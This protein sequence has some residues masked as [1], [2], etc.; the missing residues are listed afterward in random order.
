MAGALYLHGLSPSNSL[1]R[2]W[3]L[4]RR[5]KRGQTPKCKMLFKPWPVSCFLRTHGLKPSH[6]AWAKIQ[7]VKSRFNLRPDGRAAFAMARFL[8]F[9][10]WPYKDFFSFFF[11]AMTC[12][13]WDRSSLT[14]DWTQATGSALSLPVSLCITG[15]RF[16]HLTRTD[17]N[18]FLFM[19]E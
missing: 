7:R 16:I 11:L 6:N 9:H 3:F 17:S 19:S 5:S 4:T 8:I 18:P 12:A 2:W 1:F 10:S 14:R 13:L 15:S